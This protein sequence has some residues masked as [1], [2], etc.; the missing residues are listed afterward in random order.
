[1]PKLKGKE[2]IVEHELQP[3]CYLYSAEGGFAF[4]LNGG[5]QVY[6]LH[7]FLMRIEMKSETEI[8]FHY[9][10]GTFRVLG[11]KV[12]KIYKLA[13]PRVLGGVKPS[14]PDDPCC[15]KVDVREVVFEENLRDIEVF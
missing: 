12:E 2:P 11:L 5:V 10:Y 1:M 6:A 3:T 15:D 7:S 4:Q 8:Q 9:T 14:D 13:V